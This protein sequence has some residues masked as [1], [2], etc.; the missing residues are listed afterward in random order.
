M[1]IISSEVRGSQSTRTLSL[2]SINT[3]AHSI[4]FSSRSDEQKHRRSTQALSEDGNPDEPA[5]WLKRDMWVACA[6]WPSGWR[7]L[8]V[9]WRRPVWW[10]LVQRLLDLVRP[11][12]LFDR[13]QLGHVLKRGKSAVMFDDGGL[14]H[15]YD[16]LQMLWEW[17]SKKK[18][19][20]CFIVESSS[21][22][23]SGCF[24]P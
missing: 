18:R 7:R 3:K 23:R 21:L 2:W 1:L 19:A 13:K 6:S 15:F 12:R 14:R 17:Q 8:V 4:F 24:P 20:G 22:L 5:H 9:L 11:K 16:D 10:W